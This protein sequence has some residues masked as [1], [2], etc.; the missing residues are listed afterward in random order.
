MLPSL[1]PTRAI[2]DA[3][4]QPTL[5]PSSQPT[6]SLLLCRRHGPTSGRITDGYALVE[7]PAR[8]RRFR[9]LSV[10]ESDWFADIRPYEP[11]DTLS[12][13]YALAEPSVWPT[14]LPTRAQQRRHRLALPGGRHQ[15]HLRG[16]CAW[17]TALPTGRQRFQLMPTLL[18]VESYARAAAMPLGNPRSIR[19][20]NQLAALLLCRPLTYQQADTLSDGYASLN[21]RRGYGVSDTFSVVESDW[22]ADI[23]PYE[24][25]DT[26]PTATPR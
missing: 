6:R 26:L 22:F 14:L 2:A 13:G 1:S 3:T 16:A 24:P 20:V 21:P 11:A 15:H 23:R 9:H 17:P 12:D 18:L 8:L 10:V 19:L 7:P 25:A 4:E 5:D